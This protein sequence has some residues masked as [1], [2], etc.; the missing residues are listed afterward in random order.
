MFVIT[1]DQ[2]GSRQ[3]HDLVAQ[4]LAAIAAR[5]GALVAEPVRNAGDE[6]QLATTDAALALEHVLGLTRD[7]LWSVGLGIG[8]AAAD[9]P[10]DLRAA[11]GAVFY[12]A[13]TAVDQAKR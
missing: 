13:R 1:A 2:V 6:L 12:A 7:G 5:G 3:H 9:I 11:T 4:T 10:A 8:T